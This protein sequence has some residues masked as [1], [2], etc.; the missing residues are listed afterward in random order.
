MDFSKFETLAAK[1][2]ILGHPV[3]LCIVNGL[4]KKSC[5]VKQIC[6]AL[7]IPQPVISLHLSK[8]RAAGIVVGE[9]QG[10]CVCYRI[11]DRA[12]L[13]LLELLPR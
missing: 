1:L 3:R 12:T 11:V 4:A 7:G 9:R 10:S 2:R 5:H 13:K 8:L 6:E